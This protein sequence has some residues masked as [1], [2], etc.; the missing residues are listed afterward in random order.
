MSMKCLFIIN[1]LGLGNS[2]RCFA[3]IEHLKRASVEVHVLTSG[4]GYFFFADKPEVAS[5]TQTEAIHYG[6]T[7]DGRLSIVRTFFNLGQLWRAY[8]AR[9]SQLNS[10]LDLID[11][12]VVVA[13]SDYFIFPVRKRKIPL[14]GLNNSDVVVTEYFRRTS[15]PSSIRS[16][17]W[18]IEFLDYLFHKT[19]CDI[20]LSPAAQPIP[21]RHPK[22][23]R[24]GLVVREQLLHRAKRADPS[25]ERLSSGIPLVVIMLSGSSFS[26]DIDFSHCDLPCTVEVVGRSGQSTETITYHGK[27]RDNIAK[28]LEADVLV[29]N[30]GFSAVSEALVLGKPTLVLPVPNHAE[31]YLNSCLV[32]DCGLGQMTDEYTVL[33]AL[34]AILTLE[35]ARSREAR[36]LSR[37]NPHGAAEASSIILEV[38]QSSGR[39]V[40]LAA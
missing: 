38:I 10:L 26:S 6:K 30:S 32:E 13:D 5:V 18:C 9:V 19:F 2:T 39:H 34:R 37:I 17:F 36:V 21:V 7:R 35:D 3:I 24:I 33:T 16:Q 8:K 28:L 27:L 25:N 11:P 23:R 22:F 12:D 31:Q 1:G 14:I 29:I 20:I 15:K 4:N 40:Q